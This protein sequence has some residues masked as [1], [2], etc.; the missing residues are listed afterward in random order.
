[1]IQQFRGLHE[2]SFTN[3]VLI[4]IESKDKSDSSL[5]KQDL[6]SLIKCFRMIQLLYFYS[7]WETKVLDYPSPLTVIFML[8]IVHV[9]SLR[10]QN[11][12]FNI[13]NLPKF[14][15]INSYDKE[16]IVKLLMSKRKLGWRSLIQLLFGVLIFNLVWSIKICYWILCHYHF[17]IIRRIE[18]HS[19]LLSTSVH[20]FKRKCLLSLTDLS[21]SIEAWHRS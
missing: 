9:K 18:I 1:M 19:C 6:L 16:F 21:Q 8:F 3:H 5:G 2:R 14:F 13:T 11:F 7:I 20:I 10:T 15:F 17:L 4:S 12:P